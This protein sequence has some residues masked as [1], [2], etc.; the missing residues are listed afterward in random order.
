MVTSQTNSI[1]NELF[2]EPLYQKNPGKPMAPNRSLR[3][4]G[5]YCESSYE[6]T[7]YSESKKVH[8]TIQQMLNDIHSSF[9]DSLSS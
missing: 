3:N 4:H 9:T 8:C 5:L 6:T 7:G 1:N 2:L